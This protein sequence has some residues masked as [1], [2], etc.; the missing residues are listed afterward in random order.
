MQSSAKGNNNEFVRDLKR[1]LGAFNLTEKTYIE[2]E[3]LHVDLL[4]WLHDHMVIHKNIDCFLGEDTHDVYKLMWQVC[5]LMREILKYRHPFCMVFDVD[6]FFKLVCEKDSN[7]LEH[8]HE[9]NDNVRGC[10]V[11]LIL[12]FMNDKSFDDKFH[13]IKQKGF[14]CMDLD[15]MCK[16]I[17][18]RIKS[19]EKTYKEIADKTILIKKAETVTIG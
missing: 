10:V 1:L 14:I 6:R 2:V 8:Y 19:I 13:F 4:W 12:K 5:G 7:H 16:W 18:K 11:E 15:L 17:K 3:I 9:Y